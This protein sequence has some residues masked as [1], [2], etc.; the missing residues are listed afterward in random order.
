MNNILLHV[1]C[2][3]QL[4]ITHNMSEINQ[5]KKRKHL[6]WL[7]FAEV[8]VHAAFFWPVASKYTTLGEWSY[9]P[10]GDW[11]P[12]IEEEEWLG[13]SIPF[14]GILPMTYDLPLGP[15]S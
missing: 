15:T 13:P 2:V 12:K 11:E 10:S 14:K 3:S 4:S 9:S 5:F 8:F 6:F 1:S 7:M